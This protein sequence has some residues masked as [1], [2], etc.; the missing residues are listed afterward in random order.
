MNLLAW[1]AEAA[2]SCF[3]FSLDEKEDLVLVDELAVDDLEA[4]PL[5]DVG[6]SSSLHIKISSQCS[7]FRITS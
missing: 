6:G 4:A 3:S 2:E 5:L 7:S 1:W